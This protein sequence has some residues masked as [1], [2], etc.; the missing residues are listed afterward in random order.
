MTGQAKFWDIED[1]LAELSA[2]GDPLEKLSVTIDFELFRPVLALEGA[3][4]PRGV[5]RGQSIEALVPSW[6]SRRGITRRLPIDRPAGRSIL[7]REELRN[8][9]RYRQ[10]EGGA[11]EL[12]LWRGKGKKRVKRLPLQA[13]NLGRLH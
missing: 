8:R 13:A 5:D 10:P 3:T 2:E 4:S 12:R 1:R 7:P 6:R 9:N 11:D